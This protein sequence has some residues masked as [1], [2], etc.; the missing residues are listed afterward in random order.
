MPVT[1]NGTS[2]IT[3]VDGTAAAPA[4]TGTDTDTGIFFPAAN[5]LAFSTNGTEDARFDSSGNLGIGTSSPSTRLQV[6]FSSATA[7]SSGAYGNGLIIYN[8]S[9][10]T[11]QY[12][13]IVFQGEPTAGNAGQ[14]TIYG[15]TTG[16]GAM[17]LVFSTRGSSTLAERMRLDSSGNLGLGATSPLGAFEIIRNSSSA[18]GVNYPNIR[19]DNQ[20]ASG[21]TGIYFLNANTNK[22][23]F[24]VKNDVGAL[25]MGTGGSERARITSGGSLFIGTT[26][27]GYTRLFGVE[28]SG[29]VAMIKTTGTA[30]S[31]PLELW[32][33]ATSGDNRFEFFYTEAS[34]TAR[35][36]IDYNR[37]AGLTR[38]NTTSDATL[39]NIIGD[40]DG[41]KSV[42]ILKSTR[43]REYSWKEDQSN[44]TQV[45]VIAQELYETFKGAVSVG[46]DKVNVDEEGNE[47]TQYIPWA[48][49][50]T[51]FTFHLVAGWQAHERIIQQQQAII[52]Q[53]KARLDAAN[54]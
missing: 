48:V 14:A 23:F 9:T 30:T 36:S 27:I 20:N 7:Y 25:T 6:N 47:T 29:D 33:V 10:T 17:D 45:G 13:G 38:Y 44:K 49:D 42:E 24:E 15:T 35:G 2:G 16:S 40:S 46:G 43:I 26:N 21:Y 3:N 28:S 22:A 54:L 4:L 39:K 50:K 8:T 12:A 31:T 41:V 18:S 32:N 1:I 19:L 53:L 52:E 5:T 34:P 51:A 11:N 37:G